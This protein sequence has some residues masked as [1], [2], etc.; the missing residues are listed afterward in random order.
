M[1]PLGF[2]GDLA[3]RRGRASSAEVSRSSEGAAIHVADR[4]SCFSRRAFHCSSSRVPAP[5]G[6]LTC[7]PSP[8]TER[9]ENVD[10]GA[11]FRCEEG[12]IA[13]SARV[14]PRVWM[15]ILPIVFFPLRADSHGEIALAPDRMMPPLFPSRVL[16]LETRNRH[17]ADCERAVLFAEKMCVGERKRPLL[18]AQLLLQV[19]PDAQVLHTRER[20]HGAEN[21]VE[22]FWIV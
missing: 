4:R 12:E 2:H 7:T 8:E 5:R 9:P 14:A 15:S 11:R 19:F 6:G 22:I 10:V 13:G 3:S 21:P 20:R 18:W 1:L 17:S 16:S